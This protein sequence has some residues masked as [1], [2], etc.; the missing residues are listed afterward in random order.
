MGFL[1][2]VGTG[3]NLYIGGKGESGGGVIRRVGEICRGGG[4][5]GDSGPELKVG[6]TTV[7]S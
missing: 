2:V 3:G 5:G 6:E 4:A 1:E 7:V